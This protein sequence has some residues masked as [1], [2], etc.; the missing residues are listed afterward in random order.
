MQPPAPVLLTVALLCSLG[1]CSSQQLYG[2]GQSWQRN[3][4]LELPDEQARSRCLAGATA[5]YEQYKRDAE[6]ASR[7]K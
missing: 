2:A 6:A 1:A 7:P 3:E 5:P 4:C